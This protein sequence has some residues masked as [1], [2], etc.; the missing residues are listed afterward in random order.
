[1]SRTYRVTG[2]NLKAIPL[3]EGDRLLTILTPEKGLIKAVAPGARKY[4]SQLRGRMELFVV[5]QLLIAQGRSLD[6][7]TQAETL[8]SH[9]NL[10]NNLGKLASAQYLAELALALALSEQPQVEIY[11]L[12]TEHLGRLTQLA[13]T[14]PFFPLLTHGIFHLLVVAG[15]APRVNVCCLTQHQILP[16]LQV[17]NWQVGFSFDAGGLVSLSTPTSVP[18][19]ERMG[20]IELTLLQQLSAQTLPPDSTIFPEYISAATVGDAWLKIERILRNYTQYHLGRSI[21]SATLLDSL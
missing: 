15:I 8:I 21:R 11:Q 20:A 7:I 5:N 12:I 13:P 19:D 16:Q 3:G 4:Q 1:M 14:E 6:K 17:I 18:I 9:A 10:S 2:I